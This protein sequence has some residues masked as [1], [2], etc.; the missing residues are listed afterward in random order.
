MSKVFIEENFFPPEIFNEITSQMLKLEYF[1]P[2][3]ESREAHE[4]SYWHT[5]PLPRGCD[6]DKEISKLVKTKFNFNIN[7]IIDSAYTMVGAIDK[8]RPHTDE[9]NGATHQCLIYMHGEIS[10]NNGTGFYHQVNPKFLDLSIHVGFKPNRA[11][12][13]SSD[14]AH[15]PLQWAGKG[16]FRYSLCSFF[17]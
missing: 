15:A 5:H 11:V 8:P 10:N 9:S 12:F 16:A 14:V 17:N 3:K 6:V 2:P 1:P 7:K 4:G 13:F